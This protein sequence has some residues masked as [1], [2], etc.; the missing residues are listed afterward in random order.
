VPGYSVVP[1]AGEFVAELDQ[2]AY[3]QEEPF[4]STSVFASYLVQR[5]AKQHDV[6]VMLDGQGADEY[7]AGYAHYPALLLSSLARAGRWRTWRRERAATRDFIGV[8]PVPP[9]AAL[10]YWISTLLAA[11]GTPSALAIDSRRDNA[12]LS[13]D[14]RREFGAEGSRTLAIAGDALKRR[15]YADLMHGHLQELL[16]YADRNSM[17]FSREV[18]LPFLDHRLVELALSLPSSM[19]FRDG[20][21][22]RVLRDAMRGT[23]PTEILER[24][25]KVGFMAPWAQ[26][27][28][29]EPVST[30]LKERLEDARDVVDGYID[31]DAVPPASPAAL[32]VLTFATSLRQLRGVER[33]VAAVA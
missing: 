23:V 30:A 5:L 32:G 15:L 2:L 26:W 20:R 13:A 17:A 21:S 14:L 10:R 1:T 27:W 4:T 24:R 18:R 31:V 7:L 33:D 28:R 8:D 16:R 3:H 29:E 25:D 11:N 12:F 6:T 9:K 19:L 22:K